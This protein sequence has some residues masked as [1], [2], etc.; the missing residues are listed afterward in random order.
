MA[1]H[2]EVAAALGMATAYVCDPHAPW[3]RPSNERTNGLLRD[4]FTQGTD[5]SVHSAADIARVQSELNARS[6]RIFGWESPAH[7]MAMHLDTPSVLRR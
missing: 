4:D 5:L 6:S 7:R 3:Q 1:L 2:A